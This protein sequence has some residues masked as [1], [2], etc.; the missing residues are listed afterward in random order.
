[1]R[2]SLK[3][4]V[5]LLV[6]LLLLGSAPWLGLPQRLKACL[7]WVEALGPW[8]PLAFMMLYTFVTVAGLPVGPLVAAAGLLFGAAWGLL[9]VSLA[10]LLGASLAFWLARSLARREAQAW[11]Q[12]QRHWHLVEPL[13][14]EHGGPLVAVVRMLPGIPFS[15]QNYAF[16]LSGIPFRTYL[17]WT[18]I[19][20]MPLG[21]LTV[22]GA[23]TLA[24]ALSGEA[25]PTLLAGA[26]LGL[27]LL[28]LALS[29]WARRLSP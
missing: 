19:G 12:R 22:V 2:L 24:V 3:P 14:R 29:A 20:I 23:E 10:G 9:W 1:M 18:A 26:G 16:G 28:C 25:V 17:V 27:A 5:V 4:L 15:L 6:P 8:G 7:M 13:L 11:L 21:A